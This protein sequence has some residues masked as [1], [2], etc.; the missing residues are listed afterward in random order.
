MKKEHCKNGL[1]YQGKNNKPF[2]G[3]NREDRQYY[4]Q[5]NNDIANQYVR[6]Y[7]N[8]NQFPTLPFCGSYS[9][10]RGA[11][12]LSKSSHVCFDPKLGNGVCEHLH[13]PCV[14]V[15]CKSIL[16][17]IWIYGIP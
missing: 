13:V 3:K 17:K 9:K 14:C 7:C 8:T 2:M 12:G 11:R 16:D 10:P 4:V 1:L 6:M 15:A 5:D